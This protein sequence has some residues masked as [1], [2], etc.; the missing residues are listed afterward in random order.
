MLGVFVSVLH[1]EVV[2]NVTNLTI[3]N[4][5]I[6]REVSDYTLFQFDKI[7]VALI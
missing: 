7:H 5:G 2:K 1:A 3:T 6:G 4:A